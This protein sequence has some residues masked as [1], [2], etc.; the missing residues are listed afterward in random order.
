MTSFLPMLH[1]EYAQ[2]QTRFGA[3]LL[4]V[5][6]IGLTFPRES[7]HEDKPSSCIIPLLEEYDERDQTIL[8]T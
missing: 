5:V 4:G 7:G 8:C 6:E 1:H 2:F 3:Q